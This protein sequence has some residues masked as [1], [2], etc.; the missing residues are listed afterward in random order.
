MGNRLLYKGKSFDAFMTDEIGT[1][2]QTCNFHTL[3]C[4]LSQSLHSLEEVNL[5]GLECGIEGCHDQAHRYFYFPDGQ[6]EIIEEEGKVVSIN[7][8]MQ[9][10][11]YTIRQDG[12][13]IDFSVGIEVG[14]DKPMSRMNHRDTYKLIDTAD[15]V[16]KLK[17]A[18]TFD[19]YICTAFQGRVP[20]HIYKI[21]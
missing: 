18:S 6:F 17:R 10:D 20:F 4:N 15:K 2:T 8:N 13:D 1:W 11:G 14:L 19:D 3:N 5:K 12:G 16:E 9:V 7:K 21:K